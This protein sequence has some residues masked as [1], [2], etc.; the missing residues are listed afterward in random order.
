MKELARGLIAVKA[1]QPERHFDLWH[2]SGTAL[3]RIDA[4]VNPPL[5]HAGMESPMKHEIII[6]VSTQVATMLNVATNPNTLL[7]QGN[8]MRWG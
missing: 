1:G 5:R 7:V 8:E 3:S 2:T 4:G 6:M